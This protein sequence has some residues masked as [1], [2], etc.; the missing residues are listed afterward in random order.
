MP[1]RPAPAPARDPGDLEY[2]APCSLGVEAAL[3]AELVELG[4]R[5]LSTRPGGVSFRGDRRLGYL[6]NLWLRS[7]VRV[8]DL[9][10]RAPARGKDELYDAVYRIDWA[11]HMRLDQTLAV[12]ASV[13]DSALTHSSFVAL[14][15][16]DAI[17]DQFRARRGRRPSVNVNA[18]DLPL[19]VVLKADQLTIW[20]NLSGD[21]LHRRG[22]HALQVKS[23]LNEATAAGLLRLAAWDRASP[24][25]DPMCGSGTFVIEAAM[26]AAD[27]APGLERR[28]AFERWPDLD[29]ELLRTLRAEARARA[30]PTLPF[31]LEGSD[32]HGGAIAIAR[33]SAEHAGVGALARFSVEDAARFTP[34]CAPPFTVL[35]NPPYGER[36]GEGDDLVA[37]WRALGRFL[38]ERC[39][40]ARAF[41]LCGNREMVPHLGL[42]SGRQFSVMNG[43]IECRLLEYDLR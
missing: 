9:L 35:C 36:I 2:F 12:D 23:P 24:L 39:R 18:P 42:E 5:D 37:S 33:R 30:K 17:V 7:A 38:A 31:P 15:V 21:S 10:L 4:A 22:Y 43:Q 6:A 1:P 34:S 25:V 41:V 26:L 29:A 11:Q 40:G 16:K 3:T 8:Q 20:R 14:T 19:K 13:R 27:R 28:F 32:R